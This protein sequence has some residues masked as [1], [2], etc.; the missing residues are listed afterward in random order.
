MKRSSD[1]NILSS[2]KIKSVRKIKESY[3]PENSY[4]RG[5]GNNESAQKKD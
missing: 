3:S 2:K 1:K 4:A 5:I